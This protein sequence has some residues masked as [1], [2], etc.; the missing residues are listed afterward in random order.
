[1]ASKARDIHGA[2]YANHYASVLY[3]LYRCRKFILSEVGDCMQII[4]VEGVSGVGKSTTTQKLHD[5]LR[6]SG[7]SV[8]SYC[9]F[10]F[11][12]PIDFYCTAYFKQD[13]YDN[14]LIEHDTFAEAIKHNTVIAE[15]VRLV[16]YFN[17]KTPLFPKPLLEVLCKNE[18]CWM[19]TNLI[20]LVEYT[21]VYRAV[22]NQFAKNV[23]NQLDFMIF[24]GSLIHH[25]INDM[26]RNYNATS[27]QIASHLNMLLDAINVLNPK[28]IYLSTDNVAKRLRKSHISREQNPPSDEQVQFWEARK[29]MDL[30]VLQKLF[31]PCNFYDVTQENW[32]EHINTIVKDCVK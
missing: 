12:N 13:E 22:W 4:F 20:P 21:R 23:N 27:K 3:D 9:E 11:P 8:N 17:N 25:P 18:F 15:D 19:P 2:K 32:D 7:F 10:D 26:M 16:R 28:I 14:M 31:L 5:K 30:S 6:D 29:K 24:D 1:M